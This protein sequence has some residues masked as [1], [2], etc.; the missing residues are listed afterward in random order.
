MYV[1]EEPVRV[2]V[3]A[4]DD[5]CTRSTWTDASAKPKRK[6]MT[7][8]TRGSGEVLVA[9]TTLPEPLPVH[10]LVEADLWDQL[11]ADAG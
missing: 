6:R 9:G 4:H 1:T 11:P 10:D 5:V 8:E 2:S 7:W 3:H